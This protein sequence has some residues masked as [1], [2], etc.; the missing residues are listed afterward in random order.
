[1]QLEQGTGNP[2]EGNL[3]EQG[4][5]APPPAGVEEGNVDA[6]IDQTEAEQ[7]S[8]LQQNLSGVDQEVVVPQDEPVTLENYFKAGAQLEAIQQAASEAVV[9]TGTLSKMSA[10]A[11]EA[12][13]ESILRTLNYSIKPTTQ[14]PTLEAFSSKWAKRDATIVTMEAIS[15][16]IASVGAKVIESIKALITVVTTFLSNLLKNRALLEATVKRLIARVDALPVSTTTAAEISGR[17]CHGLQ[18]KGKSDI[19]TVLQITGSVEQSM[20]FF[21]T[22][23]KTIKS[24]RDGRGGLDPVG[25]IVK[26]G[27]YELGQAITTVSMDGQTEKTDLYLALPNAMSVG[28]VKAGDKSKIVYHTNQDGKANVASM[29][30]PTVAELKSG[31]AAALRAVESLRIAEK[32]APGVL[33]SVKALLRQ[34]E[35]G[36]QQS[37]AAFGSEEHKNKHKLSQ[38]ALAVQEVINKMITRLPGTAFSAVKYVT[39]WANAGI[40]N[41]REV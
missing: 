21:T 25:D 2:E 20:R 32:S 19:S 4:I 38:D 29:E 22:G 9:G 13:M 5:T 35:A 27:E 11:I 37:R 28:F 41:L 14:I 10:T 3:N 8:S 30:A 7:A 24:I 1:M 18:V 17:F 34:I 40:N 15:D 33:D 39:E 23:V 26:A 36:Y 12:S 6:N 16:S 31:L